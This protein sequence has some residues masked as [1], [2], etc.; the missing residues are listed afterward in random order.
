MAHHTA[1]DR[2]APGTY[3]YPLNLKKRYDNFI[4]G[5]WVPPVSGDYFVNLT[6]VTGQPLCKVASSGMRDVGTGARLAAESDCGS[7]AGEP[8]TA[9][10]CGN[11]G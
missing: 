3:A 6:P 1:E 5:T 10:V 7:H 9:G 8:G 4:G 2:V 11:L